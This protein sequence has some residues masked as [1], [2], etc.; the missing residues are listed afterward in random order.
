MNEEQRK[1]IHVVLDLETVGTKRDAA[2][3]EIGV[4]IFNHAGENG[5]VNVI[6]QVSQAVS[7]ESSMKYGGTVD[8]STITWWLDP[9][10]SEARDNWSLSTKSSLPSGLNEIA[11]ILGK[12]SSLSPLIW[13]NGVNF[14]NAILKSAYERLEV[15]VPWGYRQDA[16]FRTLK[17]LYKDVVPEPAFVGTPHIALDDARH[18]AVWLSMILHHIYGGGVSKPLPLD[19]TSME[20][21]DVDFQRPPATEAVKPIGEY[22]LISPEDFL[23]KYAL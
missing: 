22:E 3:L 12:Y 19:I 15:K 6:E 7:L 16:D 4:V 17:L 18:E 20:L 13:G 23:T 21:V 14:D 2:I 1:Q 5:S 8:A 10:R 9:D 11:H